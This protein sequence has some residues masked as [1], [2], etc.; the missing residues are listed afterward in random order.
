MF[1]GKY[2]F[3]NNSKINLYTVCKLMY[4]ISSSSNIIQ[5]IVKY[6]YY[7]ETKLYLILYNNKGPIEIQGVYINKVKF[8]KK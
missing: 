1:S 6:K 2:C 8:K 4:S 7:L 3:K 5:V